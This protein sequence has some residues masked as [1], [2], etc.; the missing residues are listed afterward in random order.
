MLSD[1]EQGKHLDD[2]HTPPHVGGS[3]KPYDQE[4]WDRLREQTALLRERLLLAWETSLELIDQRWQIAQDH[5][6]LRLQ[7]QRLLFEQVSE[8]S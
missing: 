3:T 6:D 8:I 7:R 1:D 2:Q 5:Q 4:H